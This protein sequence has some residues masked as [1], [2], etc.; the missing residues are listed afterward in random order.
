ME[1]PISVR[2][3]RLRGTLGKLGIP[4]CLLGRP[5][6]LFLPSI[7]SSDLF[8]ARAQLL[9]RDLLGGDVAV[10]HL[11]DVEAGPGEGGG[12]HRAPVGGEPDAPP[13]SN[14]TGPGSIGLDAL[15]QMF[16]HGRQV[17]ASQQDA[18]RSIFETMLGGGQR[19]A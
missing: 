1:P 8:L 13:P 12:G 16:E 15:N 4:F 11:E 17:Q 19:K 10:R 7:A 6:L 3:S 18:L 5:P 14:E 9:C 2:Y